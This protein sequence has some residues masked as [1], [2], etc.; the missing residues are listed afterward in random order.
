MIQT[1]ENGKKIQFGLD[2]GPLVSNLS[3]EFFFKNLAL[4][5]TRYHGQLSFCTISEETND[6]ILR[7]LSDGGTDGQTQGQ[8]DRQM[9]VIS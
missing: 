4:S 5:V 7:K 3:R 1:Q 9:R 2:L 8:T 6:P